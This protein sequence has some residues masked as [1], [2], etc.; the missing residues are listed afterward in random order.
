MKLAAQPYRFPR[1]QM[2]WDS[3]GVWFTTFIKDQARFSDIQDPEQLK[4][5]GRSDGVTLPVLMTYIGNAGR[6]LN[7]K[8]LPMLNVGGKLSTQS[9]Q[10]LTATDAGA[11]A[12]ISIASHTVQF[13]SG[14]GSVSYNSGTITG[15]AFSTLYYVYADDPTYAGGAVTYLSTTNGNTPTANDGRYYL[16]KVTTPANGA[17]DTGGGWGGGGGGGG[18]QVP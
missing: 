16:G 15:L 2:D 4:L 9:V 10:P 18:E 11:D 5:A 12:S 13:G 14:V 7:Q 3:F 17:G 8:L 1:G 6:A